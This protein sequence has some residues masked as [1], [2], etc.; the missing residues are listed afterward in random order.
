MK[1]LGYI[2]AFVLA[3]TI[4][5]GYARFHKTSL[6][7][8]NVAIAIN[9]RMISFDRFD[10]LY[11][12][13]SVSTHHEQSKKDFVDTLIMKELMIQEAQN[14]KINQ[15]ESFRMSVQNFYE[16]SLI[17]ILM[18]KKFTNLEVNLE[19]YL[20]DRYADLMKKKVHLELFNYTTLEAAQKREQQKG[21]EMT[22]LFSRLGEDIKISLLQINIGEQSKP[23]S[24]GDSYMTVKLLKTEAADTKMSKPV[25]KEK[26]IEMLKNHERDQMV[27][28]W[29]KNLREKA[30][31]KIS[32]KI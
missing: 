12:Y 3:L 20:F 21:E 11:R 19:P 1:Y 22:S 9:D 2:F 23:I 4:A 13:H 16:Q 27:S 6:V 5:I 14:E 7:E 31:I 32:N 26:V 30:N 18:E 15:N 10:A 8:K 28:E 17:K 25:D 29:I 24:M